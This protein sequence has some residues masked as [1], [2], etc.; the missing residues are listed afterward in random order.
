MPD[1]VLLGPDD[2][3]PSPYR[4]VL[5]AIEALHKARE[6]GGSVECT[7]N[8]DEVE[9]QFTGNAEIADRRL[10]EGTLPI[11]WR[12][13]AEAMRHWAAAVRSVRVLEPD[14]ALRHVEEAVHLHE[15][16]MEDGGGWQFN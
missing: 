10:A 6:R 5:L 3:R 9:Q 13:Q 7:V 2:P 15:L 14:E 12:R 1:E 8:L 4:F 11:G 16:D